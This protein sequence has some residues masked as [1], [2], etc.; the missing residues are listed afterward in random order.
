MI[1]RRI[2]FLFLFVCLSLTAFSQTATFSGTVVEEETLSFV[3]NAIVSINGTSLAQTTNE[4]GE[5]SFK[6]KIPSGEQFVTIDKDGYETY[7]ELLNV[8]D[9]QRIVMSSIQLEVTKKEKKRR[10][11]ANKSQAKDEKKMAKEKKSKIKDAKKDMEDSEKQLAKEKKKLRKKNK[12]AVV[13]YENTSNPVIANPGVVDQPVVESVPVITA[14]EYSSLQLK[15]SRIIGV[16]PDKISNIP[17]YEFID[18]WMGTPYLM[19]GANKEGID[20]SSFS[21]RLFTKVYDQYIERTAE[22]Q[23]GSRYT[24]PFDDTSFLR[25][26]DLLFFGMEDIARITHVGVYLGNNKFVNATSRKTNGK[27]GVKIDDLS[28]GYW[29]SI[30]CCAGRRIN[31]N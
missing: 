3:A 19:G 15:Y 14:N 26:G 29:R 24:D 10:K 31:N 4:R 30:F 27:S 12:D 9:G 18:E 28:D 23:K 13:I 16:T 25:E 2:L 5:F 22:S 17:L 21:Q 20:C 7:L 1:M 8:R 11:S 6:Q